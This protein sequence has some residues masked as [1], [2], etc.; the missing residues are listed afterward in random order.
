MNGMLTESPLPDTRTIASELFMY[1]S[2]DSQA[3]SNLVRSKCSYG[4][5]PAFLF[6]GKREARFLSQHLAQAFGPDAVT[7]L[8]GTYYLGLEVVEIDC[9]TF[10]FAGGRK[11][12]RM[13]E[14]IVSRQPAW[15]DQTAEQLWQSRLR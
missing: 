12:S 11:M 5:T 6:L 13:T 8:K 1:G 14:S 3:V 4:E 15:R 9:P 7:T 2:W 10:V